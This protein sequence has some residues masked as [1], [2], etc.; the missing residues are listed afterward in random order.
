MYEYER[1]PLGADAAQF[2]SNNVDSILEFLPKGT[3]VTRHSEGWFLIRIPDE[4]VKG[5]Q[6]G[7]WILR[8]ETGKINIKSDKEFKA[9]Y[10]KVRQ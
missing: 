8:H 1:I 6:N 7:S 10:R 9:T 3:E 4:C 5:I 2:Y